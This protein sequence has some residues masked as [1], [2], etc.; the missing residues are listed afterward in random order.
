MGG[1]IKTDLLLDALSPV[2][3]LE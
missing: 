3:E 2:V 1:Q